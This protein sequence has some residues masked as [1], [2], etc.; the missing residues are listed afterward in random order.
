MDEEDDAGERILDAAAELIARGGVHGLRIAE[1]ARAAGV[2]RPTIYRRWG[3]SEEIVRAVLLQRILAIGA[4]VGFGAASRADLAEAVVAFT[5]LV[6]ADALF[7]RLLERDPQVFITYA[8]QRIGRSQRYIL[9]RLAAAIEAGQ[10]DGSVRE[11]RPEEIAVMVFLVAQSA[12]LSHATV[13]DLIDP[14]AWRRELRRSVEGM[15]RP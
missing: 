2:S 6:N 7:Q 3:S 13:A 5:E 4:R 15:L 11:G 12:V 10:R 8:F 9:G 1:L 14:A